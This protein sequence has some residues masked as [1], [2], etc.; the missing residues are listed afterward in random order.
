VTVFLHVTPGPG[1][2]GPYWTSVRTIGLI[3]DTQAEVVERPD[4]VV[5]LPRRSAGGQTK[6]NPEALEPR[7][8]NVT[9]MAEKEGFEP[10]M[11]VFTHITP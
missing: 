1:I 4:K 7:G 5:S 2:V 3:D 9:L 11:Q 6:K 10:S 8:S